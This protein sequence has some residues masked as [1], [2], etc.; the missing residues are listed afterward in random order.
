MYIVYLEH[1]YCRC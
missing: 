1:I